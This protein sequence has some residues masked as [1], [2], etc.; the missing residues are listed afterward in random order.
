M[1]KKV[2]ITMDACTDQ[3]WQEFYEFN[4]NDKAQL[5]LHQ[6]AQQFFCATWD[7]ADYQ[8]TN[9]FDQ[10]SSKLIN[11]Y[12]SS[13]DRATNSACVYDNA[14]RSFF[15]GKQIMLLTNTESIDF[16]EQEITEAK[17]VSTLHWLP[18]NIDFPETTRV[19]L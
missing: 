8:L 17:K 7:V 12:F 6:E 9:S 18:L 10:M 13:C 15:D 4:A 14:R 2:E 1:Q 5:Q 16:N 3:D 11:I 19:S